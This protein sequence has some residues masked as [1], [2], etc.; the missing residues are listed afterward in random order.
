MLAT[1]K[2]LYNEYKQVHRNLKISKDKFAKL[3]PT[4]SMC[5][6]PQEGIGDSRILAPAHD[7]LLA[8]VKL[9]VLEPSL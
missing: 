6:G 1:L 3:R 9:S 4:N 2:D 8:A 7:H 5:L